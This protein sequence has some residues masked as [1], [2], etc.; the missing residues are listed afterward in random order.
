MAKSIRWCLLLYFSLLTVLS[1]AQDRTITG[2]VSSRDGNEPLV[3]VNVTV[4]GTSVKTQTNGDGKYAIRVPQGSGQLE[5]SYI[6]YTTRIVSIGSQ[7]QLNIVLEVADKRLNE[8]VVIGYGTVRKGDLT[9][10]VGQVSVEDMEKAP[11]ATFA[12]ALAGRVAGVQ[13]ASNDG[14]PGSAPNITIRG[15]GSLTQSTDPLYVVDGF[16]ME[17]FDPTTIS[18]DNVESISVLKDA[19]STAIYGARGSNGVILIETKK[20]KVG[21]ARITYN[22]SQGF[23]KVTNRMEM[24]DGYEFVKLQLE[25]FPAD[26][27]AV[28]YPDLQAG[29][30]PDPEVYRNA[31]SI[32]WQDKVFRLGTVQIHNLSV[33]GGTGGTKYLVSGSY[34]NQNGTI[35]N[36]AF[37]RFN[38]RIALEQTINKKLSTGLSLY[39]TDNHASGLV[40]A[41]DALSGTATSSFFSSIWGYRPVTGPNES[42]YDL[43]TQLTDPT[44]NAA[45]DYRINPVIMAENENLHTKNSI[46]TG[47][48]SLKYKITG[49]LLLTV[50]G[51]ADKRLREYNYFYNSKTRRGIMRPGVVYAGVQ[52][53]ANFYQYKLFSNENI[54][55]YAKAFGNHHLDVKGGFSLEGINT[56]YYAFGSQNVPNEELGLSGLDQGVPVTNRSIISDSK[57]MSFF[58]RVDYKFK[59]KYLLTASY[60]ADGSSRFPS[61]NRWGYFPSGAIAWRMSDED[62]MKQV[63]FITDA[64][65]RIGYGL[66]G[67]NRVGD[68]DYLS[69]IELPYTYYYSFNNQTP[70][71]GAIAN[72]LGNE[73]LKWETSEQVNIGY[74]LS[75][76]KNRINLTADIY[77]RTVRDLLLRANLPLVSGFSTA[78]KNVGSLKNEGL[79]ISLNTKNVKGRTFSWESS[80]NISFNRNKVLA[81]N[82]NE[83]FMLNYMSWDS[84]YSGTP[85]YRTEVGGP[86]ASFWGVIWDGVYQYSDFNETSPGVYEL[87]DEVPTNGDPRASIKPGDI[88]YRDLNND[89]IVNS[90]DRTVIGRA[91]PIHTGGFNNNFAYKNFKLNIFFQWSYGNDIMNANRIYFEGGYNIRPLMNQFASYNNRWTPENQNT[92]MFRAGLGGADSGAGPNGV[93]SSMTLE[94]GSYLRLKTVSLDYDIPS[95]YLKR[96]KVSK[97]SLGCSAQ[98]L[99]T[100]TNYT[101]MDPEVAV[102]NSILTPGFDF[103]AYPRAKTIVFSLKAIL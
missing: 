25:R 9:G 79:E 65:L 73:S 52:G 27:K 13:V 33:S 42:L 32:D 29:E 82:D 90:E 1:Y 95:K 57:Q 61:G 56:S 40:A 31:E 97:L 22:G 45:S 94:D 2:L 62:F 91:F 77:R 85:L 75:M 37:N 34:Y 78:F 17:N 38:G 16:P 47:N 93:Y 44:L 46:I 20:G 98:N 14:Q 50:N 4:K 74:D 83:P 21:K 88:K 80:F 7:A 18:P 67:N 51:R 10:A 28:Y 66:S 24:M 100:W 89:G 69:S 55:S 43:E 101:G 3:G 26:A 70:S 60:R 41:D 35:I 68:Y 23:N 72:T 63:K 11:V 58:G 12:D 76:F 87:K 99:F 30:T 59:S 49:N 103:S 6:G 64:K 81:L 54:L 84:N 36:T 92:N 86:A 96:V 19:S 5:F 8:V 53:G 48:L 102:K 39:Y 71:R 15:V